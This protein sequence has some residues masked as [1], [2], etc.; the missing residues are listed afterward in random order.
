MAYRGRWFTGAALAALF[1]MMQV[2]SNHVQ[3]TYYFLFVILALVIGYFFQAVRAGRLPRWYKATAA[4]AVA[5]L[6]AVAAN[7]P[8]LYNT[9]KYSKESMRGAHSELAAADPAGAS[10]KPPGSTVTISHS[11]PTA[12]PNRSHC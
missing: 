9:Y 1:A 5:A 6:L 2:Q 7:L 8:N 12:V 4:L 3:M 10:E 11:I